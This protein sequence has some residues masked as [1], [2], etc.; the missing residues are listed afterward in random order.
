MV[1]VAWTIALV[2]R[3]P[4]TT[5]QTYHRSSPGRSVLDS[6]FSVQ[7]TGTTTA[8]RGL[9]A[10]KIRVLSRYNSTWYPSAFGVGAH[11]SLRGTALERVRCVDGFVGDG[12]LALA[13]DRCA[14]GAVVLPRD[15]APAL[16]RGRCG[17]TF[18]VSP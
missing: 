12:A 1:S 11:A 9:S 10:T 15:A 7:R 16:A 4:P 13:R 2:E 3:R 14:G 8:A 6:P 5:G 17:G 18:V